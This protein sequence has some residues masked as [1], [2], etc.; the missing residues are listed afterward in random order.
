[1]ERPKLTNA[2]CAVHATAPKLAPLS[3]HSWT[4]SEALVPI[5]GDPATPPI[6]GGANRWIS[7]GGGSR[8][9]GQTGQR[10]F[11]LGASRPPHA[12]GDGPLSVRAVRPLLRAWGARA[13][14]RR[15]AR[16][17]RVDARAAHPRGPPHRRPLAAAQGRRGAPQTWAGA[18][19]PPADA[20][21][22]GVAAA[23]AEGRP[24]A[25]RGR[26]RRSVAQGQPLGQ[27]GTREG[28]RRAARRTFAFCCRCRPVCTL[29]RRRRRR[30][31][32]F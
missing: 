19:T 28:R 8:P 1:M 26:H 15:P 5:L 10:G 20:G 32:A 11:V 29:L 25:P 7:H 21:A 17:G 4:L 6:S 2:K 9:G 23:G 12:G 30:F 18:P 24:H 3:G 22:G 16:G 14:R 13:V 27:P 31:R